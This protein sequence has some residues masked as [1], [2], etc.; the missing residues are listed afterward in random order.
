VFLRVCVRVRVRVRVCTIERKRDS[1]RG[2]VF[3]LEKQRKRERKGCHERECVRA[4][5][6]WGCAMKNIDVFLYV[7][8]CRALCIKRG[9]ILIE[10]KPFLMKRVDLFMEFRPLF[11]E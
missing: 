4:R 6:I 3:V 2:D 5:L 1:E 9:D 7:C 10:H 11:M 8:V